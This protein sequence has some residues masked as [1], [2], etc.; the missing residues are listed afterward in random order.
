M[1][2]A[3]NASEENAS[4]AHLFGDPIYVIGDSGIEAWKSRTGAAYTRRNDADDCRLLGV[5]DH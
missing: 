3:E 4:F 5:R 1:N 2:Q